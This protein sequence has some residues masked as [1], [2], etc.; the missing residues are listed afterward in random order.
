[1]W[2]WKKSPPLTIV[3]VSERRKMKTLLFSASTML[4][5]IRILNLVGEKNETKFKG[6]FAARLLPIWVGFM[7]STVREAEFLTFFKKEQFRNLTFQMGIRRQNQYQIPFDPEGMIIAFFQFIL[8]LGNFPFLF[9]K[10]DRL[11]ILADLPGVLSNPLCNNGLIHHFST[12]LA[13][14]LGP[15]RNKKS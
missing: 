11:T 7:E 6:I 12:M 5:Q 3:C 2:K 9:F 15:P 10:W 14:W 8:A 13:N 4:N 1:M